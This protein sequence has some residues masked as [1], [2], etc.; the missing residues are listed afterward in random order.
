MNSTFI[1]T[2]T[3]I[4]ISQNTTS[5]TPNDD[6]FTIVYIICGITLLFI[7]CFSIHYPCSPT[8]IKKQILCCF[9]GGLLW[10]II[11]FALVYSIIYYPL[12]FISD[13]IMIIWREMFPVIIVNAEPY[14]EF[15]NVVEIANV[16]NVE[17]I[18]IDI[19]DENQEE[20][21]AEMVNQVEVQLIANIIPAA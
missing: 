12:K 15:A 16:V 13:R 6:S 14:N 18:V 2:F 4:F 20:Q 3:P 10:I 7:C 9:G 21:I 8:D 17:N 19:Q 11:P 5:D 1:P